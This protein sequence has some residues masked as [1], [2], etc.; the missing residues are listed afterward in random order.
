MNIYD[1]DKE[2]S[3]IMKNEYVQAVIMIGLSI[4]FVLLVMI[5]VDKAMGSSVEKI[6][7]V[8]NKAEMYYYEG[9]YEEAIREYTKMQKEEEWPIYLVKIADIYS[10]RG[11]YEASNSTLRDAVIHRDSIIAENEDI[12]LEKDKEFMNDVVTTFFMNQEPQQAITLAND[13]IAEVGPYREIIETMV[14]IHLSLGEEM[15]ARDVIDMYPIRENNAGDLVVVAKMKVS[16][17]NY[18][19]AIDTLKEAWEI[20]K[21][22]VGILDVITQVASYDETNILYELKQRLKENPDEDLYKLF[23]AKIYTASPSKLGEV[24]KII[25]TISIEN[26]ASINYEVIIAQLY[27]EQGKK[28]EFDE[29]LDRIMSNKEYRYIGYHIMA[30]SSYKDANYEEAFEYCKRS[31]IENRDYADNFGL[32][33]PEIMRAWGQSQAIESYYR[34]AISMEPYNQAMIIKIGDY[35]T[36]T[37]SQ[38]DK[39]KQYYNFALDMNPN[40]H[41]GY[42]QLGSLALLEGHIDSSLINFKK[43]I[44]LNTENGKYY[45]TIGNVYLSQNDND[46][47]ITNYRSAYLLN[48]SDALALNNAGCYYISVE[49]NLFRGV[50]N[51]DAAYD[52]MN[53]DYDL[54]KST[55]E[56]ITQNYSKAK[57]LLDD[58][59][60]GNMDVLEIPDFHL[61]Y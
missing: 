13:Y 60:N 37:T 56:K 20:D 61:F 53:R 31:I 4:L 57:K 51:L 50:I 11:E 40:S 18:S 28:N 21:N 8:A 17:G 49:Q 23:I 59:N 29:V 47:A 2:K 33:I 5:S 55:K 10:M 7:I 44:E 52:E 54:D 32:L 15:L 46:N 45:R 22:E 19:G 12:D 9:K 58:Y 24:Q 30:W 43:A 48:N 41:Y 27:K 42:Y 34:T 39:A 1:E 14:G 36:F 16:T 3:N 26:S 35:Y 25:D 6:S 38:Y